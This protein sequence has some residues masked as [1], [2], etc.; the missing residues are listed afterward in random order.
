VDSA[1]S[2]KF[3]S[4]FFR[5]V[6]WWDIDSA[7]DSSNRNR[8]GGDADAVA[9]ATAAIAADDVT[10]LIRVDSYHDDDSGWGADDDVIILCMV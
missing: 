1:P 7:T 5:S 10:S 9:D 3:G 2:L 8:C 4:S 6:L